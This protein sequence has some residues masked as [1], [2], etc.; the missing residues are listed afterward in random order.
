MPE[1]D[2]ELSVKEDELDELRNRAEELGLTGYSDEGQVDRQAARAL[3]A[4]A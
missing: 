2:P 4:R 1:R 3:T